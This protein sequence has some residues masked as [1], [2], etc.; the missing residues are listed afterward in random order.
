MSYFI[1][2]GNRYYATIAPL[3]RPVRYAISLLLL[4]SCVT[5]WYLLL[6]KP[7]N[8]Q[9]ARYQSEKK[10]LQEQLQISKNINK[11]LNAEKRKHKKVSAE[12]TS[13]QLPASADLLLTLAHD[14]QNSGLALDS[15][16]QTNHKGTINFRAHGQHSALLHFLTLLKSRSALVC[17]H[18]SIHVGEN[19]NYQLECLF[20]HV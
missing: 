11:L 8:A 14:A 9:L 4:S 16:A 1:P 10:I 17:T 3:S 19:K 15:C 13:L 5:G 18:C 20:G 2:R 6:Y 7:N 12:C